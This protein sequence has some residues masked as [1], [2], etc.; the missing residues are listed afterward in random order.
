M[1][2]DCLVLISK[3]SSDREKLG[4]REIAKETMAELLVKIK[5]PPENGGRNWCGQEGFCK[6]R[7]GDEEEGSLW[8]NQG[9]SLRGKKGQVGIGKRKDKRVHIL[10]PFFL[11]IPSGRYKDVQSTWKGGGRD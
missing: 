2:V 5:N 3:P 11:L 9:G 4:R 6:G 8:G 7:N 1:R 10:Y